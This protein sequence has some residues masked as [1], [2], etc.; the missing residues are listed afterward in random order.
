MYADEQGEIGSASAAHEVARHHESARP[1]I[2]ARNSHLGAGVERKGSPVSGAVR[3][4]SRLSISS[5]HL[6]ILQGRAPTKFFSFQR[7][8]GEIDEG[9]QEGDRGAGRPIQ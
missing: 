5:I 8:D 7:Q 9:G 1:V 4:T 6:L 2:E 3:V